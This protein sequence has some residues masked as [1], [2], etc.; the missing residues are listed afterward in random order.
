MAKERLNDTAALSRQGIR[1]AGIQL[2]ENRD[3]QGMFAR[4]YEPAYGSA[5]RAVSGGQKGRF[6]RETGAGPEGLSPAVRVLDE[7]C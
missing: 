5:D 3:P 7:D 2:A 6:Q 1:P 4:D